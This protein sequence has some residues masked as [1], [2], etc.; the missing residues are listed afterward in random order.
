MVYNKKSKNMFYNIK[1]IKRIL[2]SILTKKKFRNLV[3]RIFFYYFT[4]LK[5]YCEW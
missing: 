5:P 2:T 3:G 4:H 1:V